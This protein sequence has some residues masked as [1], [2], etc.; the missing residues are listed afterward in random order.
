MRHH[1]VKHSFGRKT[2]PRIALIRGLVMALVESERIKTTVEK[3]KEL[4][5]HVERAITLGKKG[6]L[7]SRRLLISRYPQEETVA[8]IMDNIAKRF[9]QRPGGYTRIV[10]LGP[11]PGDNADMAYIEFVDFEK[12]S[13][14]EKNKAAE[15]KD[16]VKVL[17]KQKI[18]RS[19]VV[20][21]SKK[22]V[23]MMKVS[24]RKANL[25]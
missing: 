18:K 15:S 11:R 3:A 4:R 17:R 23:R 16:Q 21:K 13:S 20:A 22:R 8:K 9:S 5:R 10:K 6:T 19:R 14:T 7:H 1:A 12:T 24:S 2:G 25:Q